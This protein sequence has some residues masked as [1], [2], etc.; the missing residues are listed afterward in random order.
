[1]FTVNLVV[2]C[3]AAVMMGFAVYMIN[4]K[5]DSLAHDNNV[6][7][8]IM[9]I[10]FAVIMLVTT[11]GALGACNL[12]HGFLI[13]FIIITVICLILEIVLIAYV[14]V[15]D[16]DTSSFIEKRWDDLTDGDKEFLEDT[17]DC[18]GLYDGDSCTTSEDSDDT[19][20]STITST[21]TMSPG[22]TQGCLV[23]LEDWVSNIKTIL[24]IIGIVLLVLQVQYNFN[25]I[26]C[27]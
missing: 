3:V 26:Y 25:E 5:W 24:L 21:T 6:I 14:A 9:F 4:A 8:V 17:F 19:L 7:P 12:S 23:E 11:I 27:N 2:F 15:D 1:M 10:V 20:E 18:C 22:D 13:S 16:V